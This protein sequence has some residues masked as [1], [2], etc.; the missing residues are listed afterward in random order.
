MY[1]H[2]FTQPYATSVDATPKS[3]YETTKVGDHTFF[4]QLNPFVLILSESTN[5]RSFQ[6]SHITIKHPWN[7]RAHITIKHPWHSRALKEREDLL[8]TG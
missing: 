7:S 1:E 4:T 3:N 8:K 2:C 6:A 5:H